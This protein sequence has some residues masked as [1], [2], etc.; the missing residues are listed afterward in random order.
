MIRSIDKIA[1]FKA[2]LHLSGL[3][4]ISYP[5]ESDEL[6][7]ILLFGSDWRTIFV[8]TSAGNHV[9][10]TFFGFVLSNLL[11]FNIVMFRI[12]SIIS[13]IT[14]F[15]FL[16]KVFFEQ[17][18]KYGAII[19][20]V[21]LFCFPPYFNYSILFRGYAL[22][23]LICFIATYFAF[24]Y[25]FIEK[26]IK[27][28]SISNILFTI[29]FIHLPTTI[30]VW[31]PVIL[32]LFTFNK[33]YA[34]FF[35]IIKS[36]FYPTIL[37]IIILSFMILTTG[38]V[39]LKP[40]I[41]SF[42]DFI[43]TLENDTFKLIKIGIKNVFFHPHFSMG[44]STYAAYLNT[45]VGVF[46]KQ[47]YY[48]GYIICCVLILSIL[49]YNLEQLSGY[50]IKVVTMF[51][52]YV[53]LINLIICKTSYLRTNLIFLPF[54]A[55][56]IAF[57]IDKYIHLTLEYFS[58]NSIYLNTCL[59]IFFFVIILARSSSYFNQYQYKFVTKDLISTVDYIKRIIKNDFHDINQIE[60]DDYNQYV[61]FYFMQENSKK[62]SINDIRNHI[63]KRDFKKD[64]KYYLLN[65]TPSRFNS[66]EH[67]KKYIEKLNN[68]LLKIDY[69]NENIICYSLTK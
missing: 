68:K 45:L 42:N 19:S 48:L 59:L 22:Q 14:L 20:C 57:V 47:P 21:I 13:S 46:F 50:K 10:T 34:N 41:P 43:F 56:V 3:F 15:I 64:A 66:V 5:V 37:L 6:A 16:K 69:T 51:I 36:F 17:N 28:I 27:F 24:R 52:L 53:I 1:I 8:K 30:Y 29:S 25:I 60:S 55:Y 40:Q 49:L 33:G 4:F 18:C 9:L 32:T 54:I 44:N 31:F 58:K 7:N 61:I 38:Y 2:L 11:G 65:K 12:V 39:A 63:K 26:N 35:K 23:S 67:T 62:M